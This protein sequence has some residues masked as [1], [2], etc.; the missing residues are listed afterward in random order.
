MKQHTD[1]MSRSTWL[2]GGLLGLSLMFMIQGYFGIDHD[3]ALYLGEV[4]RLR[5]PDILGRDLFFSHGS[6]GSYTLFPYLVAALL[7]FID[8]STFFLWATVVGMV[9]FAAA[10][11]LALRELLPATQRYL[12]WLA[13]LCLPTAY[14]AYR[15]FGYGEPFFTPRLYAEGLCLLAIAQLAR[16]RVAWGIACLALAAVLHPLQAIGAGLVAW[17]WLVSNSRAWL[18]ALWAIPAAL[19]LGLAGI[20]PFDGLLQSLDDATYKAASTY[21]THLFVAGWRAVDFQTLAFDLVVLGIA[22]RVAEGPWRRWA[23]AALLGVLIALATSFILADLMHLVLPTGLQLWRTHWLAHWLAMAAVG[24][25]LQRD[26][27]ARDLPRIGLLT[28]AVTLAYGRPG[29]TWMPVVFLYLAWPQACPRLRPAIRTSVWV[30]AFAA[31]GLFFLDYIGQ[32]HQSFV[33]A[34]HQLARVPFDRAFFT[35]PALSLAVALVGTWAWLRGNRALRLALFAFALLP[36]STYAAYRWDS[37][38]A[39]Y[40]ALEAHEF[41]PALF[42]VAIPEDAQVYWERASVVANWL[43]LNRADYY[44]PQQLSGLVFS[45]GAARE[46]THR[47]DRLKPLRQDVQSCL[48]PEL[49][50]E[51]RRSCRI[52]EAAMHAACA[53]DKASPPPDYLILPYRQ[54]SPSLGSWSIH[55]P[56]AEDPAMT[57]WL[58]AC[59]DIEAGSRATP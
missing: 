9:F 24:W 32:I 49:P 18:H 51:A 55:D 47:M 50:A 23:Q 30:G 45:P 5:F 44:S 36:L 48:K 25:M 31:V 10:S 22:A 1:A 41:Q 16:G 20:A 38:P 11:W 54:S 39:L 57:Y 14:G 26:L 33:E 3:S 27:A 19:I 52:S 6:Q 40:K 35:Y 43:V 46:F 17:L 37:R 28:L 15:I 7:P 58:Y 4:M 8:V 21:S 12:P 42:G 34:N 59:S 13:L 53:L 2:A 29:W 56:A